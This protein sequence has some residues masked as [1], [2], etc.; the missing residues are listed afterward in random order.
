[1]CVMELASMQAGERFSDHPRAVSPTIACLLRWYNDLLDDE[2]RQ[3]LRQYADRILG[4]ADQPALEQLRVQRLMAW[5]DQAS[6]RLPARL[7]PHR[8]QRR[9]REH[10]KRCDPESAVQRVID[11]LC[12][13]VDQAHASVLALL[14][15]LIEP[16]PSNGDAAVPR[17]SQV[18]I[19]AARKVAIGSRAD[20]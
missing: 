17:D 11:S 14:D 9:R 3:D 8:R 6:A 1:V 20:A 12:G 13:S 7:C 15:E 19:G 16:Q 2:R 18:T 10:A 4:T 5:A